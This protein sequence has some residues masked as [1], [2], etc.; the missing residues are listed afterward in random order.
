MKNQ[1][2]RLAKVLAVILVTQTS[3][4]QSA[5]GSSTSRNLRPMPFA[6]MMIFNAIPDSNISFDSESKEQIKKIDDLM[7]VRSGTPRNLQA[8]LSS[9]SYNCM[10]KTMSFG[11][12]GLHIVEKGAELLMGSLM[13]LLIEQHPNFGLN[14]NNFESYYNVI[15]PNLGTVVI[16]VG[17]NWYSNTEPKSLRIYLNKTYKANQETDFKFENEADIKCN[18][19]SSFV[20]SHGLFQSELADYKVTSCAFKRVF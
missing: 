18:K 15:I 17:S 14:S 1:F 13:K 10:M 20:G 4:A 16:E 19:D 5:S 3:F 8:M 11:D 12:S 2:I 7:C 6:N 9:A